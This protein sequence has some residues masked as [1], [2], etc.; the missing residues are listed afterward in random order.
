MIYS[1]LSNLMKR[2]R[3]TITKLANDT[4]ISRTTLT[5]LFHN[6]GNGIQFDTLN[7][8]CNYFRI[9][10]NELLVFVP[11]NV[12][13]KLEDIGENSFLYNSDCSECTL[14]GG[15]VFS[16]VNKNEQASFAFTSLIT[17]LNNND[18]VYIE[19]EVD[20]E[21]IF[22]YQEFISHFS[23]EVY[24]IVIDIMT[25]KIEENMQKQ[26]AH[27]NG[28]WFSYN[29]NTLLNNFDQWDKWEIYNF[30]FEKMNGTK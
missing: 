10:I 11:Y 16:N 15:I 27:I 2:N 26:L 30:L 13:I 14:K 1:K 19:C 3:L 21:H 28:D 12:Q 5:S 24:N 17:V 8:L 22:A 7:V 20:N 25:D 29:Y 18:E 23:C 9:S 6:T 4:G